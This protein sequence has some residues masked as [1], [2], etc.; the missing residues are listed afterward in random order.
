MLELIREAMAA[1]QAEAKI[2]SQAVRT[3][4]GIMS[5]AFLTSVVFAP[6]KAGAR[7][8]LMAM[9]INIA[10]L[11]FVKAAMPELSRTTIGT[12]VHLLF[13]TPALFMIWR[14][15]ARETRISDFSGSTGRLYQVW[16]VI[17]S[18]IMA[19]SL[20]LDARTAIGWLV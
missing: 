8:I 6:W 18:L 9:L 5:V 16:L 7:W 11:V 1:N 3:W 20:V 4:M 17:A 14:L 13:W 10:G 2:Y 15:G 12:M 19:T